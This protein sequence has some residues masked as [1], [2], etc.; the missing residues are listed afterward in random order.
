MTSDFT[1]FLTIRSNPS[2]VSAAPISLAVSKNR[3]NCG[4]SSGGGG[5]RA[6]M[7][8]LW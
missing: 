1:T 3:S 4:F 7:G 2:S 8:G 6:G 5:L